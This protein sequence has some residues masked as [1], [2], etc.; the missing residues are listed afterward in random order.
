M[1]EDTPKENV[2][3]YISTIFGCPYLGVPS[4]DVVINAVEQA[5]KLGDTIVLC[6]T[7]GSADINT[8]TKILDL[9]L[10]N[11][12][13]SKILKFGHRDYLM[14]E[15]LAMNYMWKLKTQKKFMN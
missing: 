9:V 3:V 1:L 14:L 10:Q 12:F 11:L 15:S 8:L 7:I 5:S 6:D 2:R 4:D 13:Q